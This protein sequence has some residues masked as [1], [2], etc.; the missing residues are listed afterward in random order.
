MMDEDMRKF[1]LDMKNKLIEELDKVMLNNW[2]PL[3][4]RDKIIDVVMRYNFRQKGKL[5]IL[6]E[7]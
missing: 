1:K 3:S 2:F 5:Q 6:G 7:E 4:L